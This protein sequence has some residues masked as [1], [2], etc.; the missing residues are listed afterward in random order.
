[1]K[2]SLLFCFIFTLTVLPFFGESSSFMAP[3]RDV[4]R[5]IRLLGSLNSPK[6]RSVFPVSSCSVQAE[7]SSSELSIT[8]L[9][10]VGD[11]AVT[12]YSGAG[13]IIY[14]RSVDTTNEK[15]LL[16]D[17]GKWSRGEYKICFST[18]TGGSLYGTFCLS[19]TD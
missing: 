3:K 1:M 10:N 15:F 8:F 4:R 19:S 6:V 13:D 12:V 2:K 7:V 5:I 18:K 14:E 11:I 17:V 16:I 9:N